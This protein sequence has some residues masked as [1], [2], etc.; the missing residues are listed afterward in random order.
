M[1]KLDLHIGS[2]PAE[3]DCAQ[4]GSEGYAFRARH[5]CW[6]LMQQLRRMFGPEP[7]G[8]KLYIKSNPH[9]F[10]EYLSANCSYPEE[11]K[12][13]LNYAQRCEAELPA[14]WDQEARTYLGLEPTPKG[15]PPAQRK[16]TRT[17]RSKT[18]PQQR[19]G[20]RR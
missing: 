16:R 17:S 14:R 13:G 8:T 7:P 20:G 3:E 11:D 15:D 10:G 5:E 4:V 2:T 12:A 19:K 9:D 1:A 18:K 6:A